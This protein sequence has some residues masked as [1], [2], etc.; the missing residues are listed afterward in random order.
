LI[1]GTT[2]QRRHYA[3]RLTAFP[4]GHG[5][6]ARDKVFEELI[7]LDKRGE[8]T[9]ARKYDKVL[10][11]RRNRIQ[12]FMSQF[13]GRNAVILPLNYNMGNLKFP[14]SFLWSNFVIWSKSL[15]PL[16]TWPSC[17]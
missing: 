2:V 7:G 11:R 9:F 5:P 3:E 1:S 4:E 15:L 14:L 6:D 17:E 12:V 13:R 10:A 16:T 8:M